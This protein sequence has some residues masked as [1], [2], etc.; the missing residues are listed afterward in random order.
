MQV[1]LFCLLYSVYF[2]TVSQFL[3]ALRLRFRLDPLYYR[4]VDSVHTLPVS[5]YT[6]LLSCNKLLSLRNIDE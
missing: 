6:F 4:F 5:Y 1:C 2:H 3:R